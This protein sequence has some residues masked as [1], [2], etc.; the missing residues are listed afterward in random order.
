MNPDSARL[1]IRVARR[2]VWPWLVGYAHG[3]LWFDPIYPTVCERLGGSSQPLLDIGCGMGLH[4]FYLRDRG[5]EPEIIGLDVDEKKI[6]RGAKVASR[7]YP[8]IKLLPGSCEEL[9]EFSGNVT[10]LD[11]L[12]YLPASRQA[13][14][15]EEIAR[16]VAPGCWCVIRT[17]PRDESWRFKGTLAVERLARTISWMTEP[18]R[19]FPTL[20]AIKASFPESEFTHE[21][22]PLWG[23]TPF[24]SWLLA[25]QR[26]Q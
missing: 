17:S 8:G 25:F 12:H 24:N 23:V 2:Y 5:F 14:V 26:K 16:R 6:Q 7:H 11:V 19:E 13:R 20:E 3:K 4:A 15:L 1:R 22:R 18:A 21:I 10:M 9:P